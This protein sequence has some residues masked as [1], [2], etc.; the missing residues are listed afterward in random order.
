MPDKAPMKWC[1]G[2][3][4]LLIFMHDSAPLDNSLEEI[5][6]SI[7]SQA[8]P[9]CWKLKGSKFSAFKTVYLLWQLAPRSNPEPLSGVFSTCRSAHGRQ[10]ASRWLTDISLVLLLL[11]H[12]LIQPLCLYVWLGWGFLGQPPTDCIKNNQS[13]LTVLTFWL[14]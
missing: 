3:R 4:H 12:L 7:T 6:L 9:F 2:W 5:C 10:E 14:F 13:Y 11:L 1:H 8:L